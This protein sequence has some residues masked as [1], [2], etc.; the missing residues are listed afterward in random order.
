M[1][2]YIYIFFFVG[3]VWAPNL[4]GPASDSQADMMK[5]MSVSLQLVHFLGLVLTK[6]MKDLEE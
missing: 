5:Y 6:R 4:Y 3:T 1:L 2:F